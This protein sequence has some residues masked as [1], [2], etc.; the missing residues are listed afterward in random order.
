M[1]LDVFTHDLS[2]EAN[3]ARSEEIKFV[4]VR[5]ASEETVR[6]AEP[7]WI[8]HRNLVLTNEKAITVLEE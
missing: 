7:A 6:I 8:N 4:V 2:N 1:A 3:V 5:Q